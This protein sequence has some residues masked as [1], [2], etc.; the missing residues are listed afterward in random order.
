MNHL[1]SKSQANWL[2]PTVTT[3]F[4]IS[5]AVMM[6]MLSKITSN[7]GV[8]FWISLTQNRTGQTLLNSAAGASHRRSKSRAHNI[9]ISVC[10]ACE[11]RVV[12]QSVVYYS[13]V[14]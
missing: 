3:M 6:V 2:R 8:L 13:Y 10:C 11:E 5:G 12:S 4:K 1:A 9:D 14:G 7:D